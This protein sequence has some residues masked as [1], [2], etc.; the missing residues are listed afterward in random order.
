[1]TSSFARTFFRLQISLSIATSH[2][3]FRS[4]QHLPFTSIELNRHDRLGTSQVSTYAP[5]V[6]ETW[7]PTKVGRRDR[8]RK[9]A[10]GFAGKTAEQRNRRGRFFRSQRVAGLDPDS[11]HPLVAPPF[12][13]RVISPPEQQVLL[14]PRRREVINSR[15]TEER[16]WYDDFIA[17]C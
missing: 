5:V 16:T 10:R 7:R 13:G 11:Q 1:M 4:S 9:S 17:I 2:L 15:S 8:G 3:T 6:E 14:L 12:R